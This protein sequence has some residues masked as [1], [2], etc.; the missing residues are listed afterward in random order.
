MQGLFPGTFRCSLAWRLDFTFVHV[1]FCVDLVMFQ[2][3]FRVS[4]KDKSV[5]SICLAP[6]GFSG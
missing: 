1:T 4:F 3:H 5:A 2:V 6:Q